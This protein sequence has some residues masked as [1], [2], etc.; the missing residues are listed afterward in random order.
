MVKCRRIF[1]VILVLVYAFFFASTNFFYHSHLIADHRL[2]H[3]HPFSGADHSH[4]AGQ[5]LLITAADSSFYQEAEAVSVPDLVQ[6][7]FQALLC[8]L[9]VTS[10]QPPA[11]F[12]FSLRAPPSSC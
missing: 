2:V 9:D 5:V 6:L 4:T 8:L 12:S 10:E 11:I 7:P 3:S 1:G